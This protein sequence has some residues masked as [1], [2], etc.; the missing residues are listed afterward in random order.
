MLAVGDW[1]NPVPVPKAVLP[2]V[3]LYQVMTPVAQV[4]FSVTAVPEQIFVALTDTLVGI[5]GIV[6]TLTWLVATLL[7]W[8]GD[9]TQ[10]A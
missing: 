2:V 10:A 8:Q 6:V 7:L 5:A 9:V 4:A 3:E 1:L